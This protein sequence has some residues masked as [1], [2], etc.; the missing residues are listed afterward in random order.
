MCWGCAW[1]GAL[2]L[3]AQLP[4]PSPF[5]A[6]LQASKLPP[7]TSGRNLNVTIAAVLEVREQPS[8]AQFRRELWS[9]LSDQS[10]AQEIISHTGVTEGL[11]AWR[12]LSNLC[13]PR[14]GQR[15]MYDVQ[16]IVTPTAVTTNKDVPERRRCQSCG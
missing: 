6:A 16:S 10:E 12:C 11:E 5:G 9:F 3:M 15:T 13:R 1:V 2:R 14:T 8:A 4:C 7:G